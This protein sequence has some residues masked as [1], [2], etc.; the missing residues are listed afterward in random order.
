MPILR[1]NWHTVNGL[2]H[3]P[4]FFL[5]DYQFRRLGRHALEDG[6]R[7]EECHTEILMHLV[8]EVVLGR[9]RGKRLRSENSRNPC[10]HSRIKLEHVHR[11]S[12]RPDR[13]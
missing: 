12:L 1:T 7:I 13:D 9:S 3:K 4:R 11:V 8:A 5:S 10:D 6:Y 2:L